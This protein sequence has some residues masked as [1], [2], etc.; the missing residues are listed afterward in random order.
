MSINLYYAAGTTFEKF[1]SRIERFSNFF[2]RSNVMVRV[3]LYALSFILLPLKSVSRQLRGT[4]VSFRNGQALLR[5]I[6]E[7]QKSGERNWQERAVKIIRNSR[8]DNLEDEM[9]RLEGAE[10]MAWPEA[11]MAAKAVCSVKLN[12]KSYDAANRLRRQAQVLLAEAHEIKNI[13]AKTHHLF[14]HGQSLRWSLVPLVIKILIREFQPE[15][16]VAFYKFLRSED[17]AVSESYWNWSSKF[18]RWL[19]FEPKTAREY[20]AH[21]TI[22]YDGDMKTRE[23]LLSVDAYFFNAQNYESS[24]YFLMNN[25][26]IL[27]RKDTTALKNV[28]LS[29]FLHFNKNASE[30]LLDQLFTRLM[31]SIEFTRSMITTGN[32]YVIAIPKEKSIDAQYRAHPLGVPC[33]CHKG[34]N[35]TQILES[36]QKGQLDLNT[37]CS[38][39]TLPIPQYRLFMPVVMKPE[40]GCKIFRLNALSRMQ[41]QP[42]KEAIKKIAID[43]H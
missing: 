7:L 29:I 20:M 23:M 11:E 32:L 9:K 4:H 28:I 21:N 10:A 25:N 36:L 5:L 33:Y 37:K 39:Q 22:I 16:E 30:Q 3:A 19:G 15:Q 34:S 14:L 42:I 43:L 12:V 35:H 38:M 6:D 26:N 31:K 40:N 8:E 24:L 2:D 13:Y 17:C 1:C 18:L 41:R 27:D